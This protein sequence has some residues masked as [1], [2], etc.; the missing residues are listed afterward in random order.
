M[1]LP[2]DAPHHQELASFDWMQ[3]IRMS[4]SSASAAHGNC[5]VEV[6]TDVSQTLPFP[7]LRY[8]TH[9]RRLMLWWLEIAACYLESDDFDRDTISL[10][11]DQ[12]IYGDLR[13][14]FV[15]GMDL[16]ILI[17]KPPKD[18]PGLAILNGV[19]FWPLAGKPQLSRFYRLALAIAETLP[20]TD[21]VWGADT[22]ALE[23]LLA[24]LVVGLD[25]RSGLNV[26]LIRA[27]DV[28]EAF[29]GTGVK[30]LAQGKLTRHAISRPVLD[31]RNLRKPYMAGVYEATLAEAV[32]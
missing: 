3:A 13:K 6:L 12:L 18:G 23:R 24:P 21:I 19:Q 2:L 27:D 25:D 8:V 5:Q 30:R 20:E 31:F 32:A 9:H 4:L 1:S 7:M 26:N 22:L 10:D 29:S 11:A 28:I 15:P 14:W 17:R 16:G